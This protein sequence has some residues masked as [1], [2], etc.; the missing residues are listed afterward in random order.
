MITVVFTVVINVKDFLVI[1]SSKNQNIVRWY[2][3]TSLIGSDI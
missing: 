2:L 3:Y 1:I